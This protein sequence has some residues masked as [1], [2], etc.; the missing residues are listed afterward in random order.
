MVKKSTFT[1]TDRSPSPQVDIYGCPIFH[2]DDDDKDLEETKAKLDKLDNEQQEEMD[3]IKA[4]LSS[5]SFFSKSAAQTLTDASN[6][7]VKLL[8]NAAQ[9]V[10]ELVLG[11]VQE[12]NEESEDED[13]PPPPPPPPRRGRSPTAID[14]ST[15]CAAMRMNQDDSVATDSFV[16]DDKSEVD[17][18]YVLDDLATLESEHVSESPQRSVTKV[19]TE[20]ATEQCAE[21]QLLSRPR[22]L[23]TSL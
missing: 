11:P 20:E 8:G 17:V 12:G 18:H 6:Q 1:V 3:S 13:V 19:P 23:L 7:G 2:D 21:S 10:E 16:L 4:M 14:D 9:G 5:A 15:N 22:P